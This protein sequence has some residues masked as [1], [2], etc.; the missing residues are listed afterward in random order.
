MRDR[1]T[2][3]NIHN[4]SKMQINSIGVWDILLVSATMFNH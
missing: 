2:L 4:A 1:L 3:R